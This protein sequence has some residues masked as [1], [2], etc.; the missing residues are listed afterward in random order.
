[1]YTEDY[2]DD[3]PKTTKVDKDSIYLK[4]DEF[5][6]QNKTIFKQLVWIHFQ[7]KVIQFSSS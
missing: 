1:M 4:Y 5:V 3:K 6:P 2:N 7:Y